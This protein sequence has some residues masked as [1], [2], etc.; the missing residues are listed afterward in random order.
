MRWYPLWYADCN[1]FHPFFNNLPLYMLNWWNGL[2]FLSIWASLF[3]VCRDVLLILL[4]AFIKLNPLLHGIWLLSTGKQC[5]S[6][7]AGISMLSD[8]DLHCPLFDSLGYFW[9][10]REQ[11]RSRSDDRDVLTYMDLHCLLIA[12][13]AVC[14]E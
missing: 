14:M 13:K 7:S 4:T 8:Q 1:K 5:R 3:I 2:T 11:C 10:S 6:R 9:P 12:I